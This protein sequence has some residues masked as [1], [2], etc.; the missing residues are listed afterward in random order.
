MYVLTELGYVFRGDSRTA[1]TSK[2][3]LFVML[4]A[5]NYYH[6]ELHLGYC[7]SPNLPLVL[8]CQVKEKEKMYFE[9]ALAEKNG[10][11]TRNKDGL[12]KG[13]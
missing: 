4:E 8:I 6:K 10:S 13:L 3:E 1:A 7:S 9:N 11:S 5:I 2:V 12:V